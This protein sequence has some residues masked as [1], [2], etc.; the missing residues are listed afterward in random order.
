MSKINKVSY[1]FLPYTHIYTMAI[2]PHKKL[3]LH[4]GKSK[5][6]QTCQIFFHH[7][8]IGIT[9]RKRTFLFLVNKS[10]YFKISSN[11]YTFEYKIMCDIR[12]TKTF[13]HFSHSQIA[14]TVDVLYSEA[15]RFKIAAFELSFFEF[16]SPF[17][18]PVLFAPFLSFFF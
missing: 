17:L 4:S 16:T 7:Y 5:L 1:I 14:R 11:S 12:Y 3:T 2:L 6:I 8:S 9:T 18:E 15:K 10:L 13:V